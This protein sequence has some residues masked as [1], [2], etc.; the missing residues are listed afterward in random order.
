MDRLRG[1]VERGEQREVDQARSRVTY[2]SVRSPRRCSSGCCCGCRARARRLR[3]GVRAAVGRRAVAR[4]G[5]RAC[6]SAFAPTP[7][8]LANLLGVARRAVRAA[9]AAPT[10]S[11]WRS[12]SRSARRAVAAF[13]GRR[14]GCSTAPLAGVLAAVLILTRPALLAGA[15]RGSID[16]PALALTLFALDALLRRRWTT[17]LVLLARGRAAAAGG[18]AAVVRGRRLVRSWR[19]PAA[20][21]ARWSRS[22]SRPRSSGALA[23]LDRSRATRCSR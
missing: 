15:L 9:G 8:P 2:A 16:I 3:H 1:L 10:R 13:D 18:V 11:G 12:R 5:C 7:H 6:A 19:E 20:R 23:D 4:A 14:A 21:R 22:P 17:A